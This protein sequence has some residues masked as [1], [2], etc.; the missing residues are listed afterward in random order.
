MIDI[1]RWL[2]SDSDDPTGSGKLTAVTTLEGVAA[3]LSANP[4]G[5]LALLMSTETGG[6]AAL[7]RRLMSKTPTGVWDDQSGNYQ[8]VVASVRIILVKPGPCSAISYRV[9]YTT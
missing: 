2:R 3:R 6:V 1:S 7:N 4:L 9:A 5:S 8:F